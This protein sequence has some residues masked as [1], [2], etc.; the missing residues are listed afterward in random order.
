MVRTTNSYSNRGTLTSVHQVIYVILWLVDQSFRER[1][2]HKP[3][4]FLSSVDNAIV[5]ALKLLIAAL[6][7]YRTSKT[8]YHPIG[9]RPIALGSVVWES[10]PGAE[11]QGFR[12]NVVDSPVDDFVLMEELQRSPR[13]GIWQVGT[14][15][16]ILLS[17]S[18]AG[19]WAVH[20]YMVRYT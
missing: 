19:L 9:S 18:A 5:E 11:Q 6:V 3:K 14:A 13:P 12:D 1:I 10:S 15:R 8:T 2:V 4:H 7:W 17:F 20:S 16:S